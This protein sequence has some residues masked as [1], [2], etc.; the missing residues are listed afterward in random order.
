M[1]IL[2]IICFS[3]GVILM[4]IRIRIMKKDENKKSNFILGCCASAF[5]IIGLIFLFISSQ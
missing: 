3:I 2:S 1:Q 4:A 5:E